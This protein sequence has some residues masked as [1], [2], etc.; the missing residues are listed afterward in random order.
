MWG[1][2]N[3]EV[4]SSIVLVFVFVLLLERAAEPLQ[5]TAIPS[6]VQF[7]D[8]YHSTEAKA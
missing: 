4:H 5:H 8:C 2:V 3:S 7:S 1:K 6:L